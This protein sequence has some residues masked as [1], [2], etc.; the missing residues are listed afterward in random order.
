MPTYKSPGDIEVFIHRFEQYCLTQNVMVDIKA[1]LLLMALDEATFTVVKRELTDAERA[2]YEIVKKHLLKRFDLLKDAGQKRL[3][4]RQARREHG[5]NI[6]EFYTA[7]LGMA[8]KAFPGESSATVDKMILDQ[9]ICGCG[10]EKVRMHLIKKAPSTSREALS[11]AVTYQAAIKYNE[12]LRE[13]GSSISPT[14]VE[15]EQRGFENSRGHW[16]PQSQQSYRNFNALSRGSGTGYRNEIQFNRPLIWRSYEKRVALIRKEGGNL[17]WNRPQVRFQQ[18]GSTGTYENQNRNQQTFRRNWT[19]PPA[20][21]SRYTNTVSGLSQLYYINGIFGN[22]QV[23]ILI[24]SGSAVTIM[25]EEIWN[26]IKKKGEE[27]GKVLFPLRSATQHTLEVLG[28]TKII[29]KLKYKHTSRG[30]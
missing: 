14:Y 20:R 27:L 17:N 21:G 15:R 7:L 6:E 18:T 19:P 25:D 10:E 3:I 13:S 30:V 12:N 2:D 23:P 16:S 9:L 4:F 5:Q 29:L 11:Q 8:A 22:V 1:N 24:D 28:Q 26:L